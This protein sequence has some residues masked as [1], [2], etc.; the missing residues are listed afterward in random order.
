VILIV[1]IPYFQ[2]KYYKRNPK[3]STSPSDL[4]PNLA[5]SSR[6]WEATDLLQTFCF[7]NTDL[8]HTHFKVFLWDW[9]CEF[10]G[11]RWCPH[12]YTD[13]KAHASSGILTSTTLQDTEQPSVLGMRNTA[14]RRSSMDPCTCECVEP[15]WR[16]T[17]VFF[18]WRI[19]TSWRPQKKWGF[20]N[21]TKVFFW[22]KKGQNR[23]ILRKNKYDIARFRP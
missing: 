14:L 19:F 5:K 21:Y 23:H 17:S 13:S 16:N 9:S 1:K 2:V 20:L 18:S 12:A 4:Y 6:A 22:K 7:K 11:E 3:F 15:D 10:L 8:E